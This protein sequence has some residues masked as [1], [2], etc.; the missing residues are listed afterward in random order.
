MLLRVTRTGFLVVACV[1]DKLNS[2]E[3]GAE[4]DSRGET[5]GD[6]ILTLFPPGDFTL[7]QFLFGP[8]SRGHI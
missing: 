7:N 2:V 6:V 8:S 4:R 1:A 5:T 3:D